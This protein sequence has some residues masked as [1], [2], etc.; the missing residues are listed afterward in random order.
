MKAVIQRVLSAQLK[1]EDKII[2]S[3][4]KG[5]VIFLGVSVGDGE[6]SVNYMVKK[7]K[8]VKE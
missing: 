6:D 1:V 2:S 8:A 5:Y 7:N 3:I 4:N